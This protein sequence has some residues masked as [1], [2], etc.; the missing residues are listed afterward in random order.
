MRVA[1]GQADFT[2]NGCD[3]GFD[4]WFHACGD[5][6]AVVVE[7]LTD[8]RR[9]GEARRNGKAEVC[10]LSEVG[11]LATQQVVH[12]RVALGCAAAK[13]IGE[14]ARVYGSG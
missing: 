13:P 7:R 12:G 4:L 5:L 11:A 6:V 8:F 14:F 2:S 10:H 9:N 3:G 1:E